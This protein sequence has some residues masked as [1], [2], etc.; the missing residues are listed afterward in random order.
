MKKEKTIPDFVA[1][2]KEML[3][4][5]QNEKIFDRLREKNKHSG[6]YYATLDGPVTANYTMGLHHAFNRTFKDAMIKFEAMEG[7]DQHYQNGFDAHG[8]PVE[9]WVEKELGINS[10]K[11]IET[12]GIERFVDKCMQRV[13]KYSALITESSIRLGQW[14]DWDHSYYTNS[15]E[16]I[17]AIWHFLKECDSHGWIS[18]SYRVSPWCTRC[19]TLVAEHDM[20]GYDVYRDVTC[21]AVFFRCPIRNSNDDILVWTTTPWTLC[22]NVA[23]AVNPEKDYSVVKVKS[24][25]RNIIVMSNLVKVLKSDAVKVLRQVKGSDLVGLE[26]ETC[27]PEL[28]KQNFTHHIV[29][30][31]EVD[32]KEGSGA[33]HIAPGCGESDF[34][35]GQRLGL[36]NIVP[37]D[38]AGN[39]Y[40]DFGILAGKNGNTD[41]TRDFVFEQLKQRGKLYYFHDYTHRYPHCDR[42]KQPL[43]YRLIPQWVIKMDELRPLLISAIDEVEFNPPFMKKRMLDWL[44]NMGDWSISRARYYG[45]PLPIYPCDHCGE[46]TVVGSLTELKNLSGE[47][48]K[49]DAMPHIH[50][51]YIDDIQ[52]KCPKCGQ[53]VARIKEVGDCWLDAGITPFSTKKYFSDPEFFNKNFPIEAVI[54]GKEQIRLWF[55]SLLVMSVVLTGK[56][57]YK[58]V[59][60]TPMLL[61]QNGKKLSKSAPNIV[62][63]DQCFEEIGADVIRYNFVAT[64][65]GNDVIFSRNTCDEVKRKLLGFWNSY[66]FLNTY[67]VIDQPDL[68]GYTPR[69]TDLTVLDKWL[70]TR[71]NQFALVAER[72]YKKQEFGTVAGEF[73]QVVEDLSNWY[74]RTNRRRFYKSE[75]DS[76]TKN[77]YFCLNYAIKNL[78]MVMFPIVPFMTEYIWQN[79]VRQL[80]KNASD[81]V[82]LFGYQTETFTVKGEHLVEDTRVAQN[83]IALASK[84]RN[85][86]QLK[87]KQ[88]LKEMF[89]SGTGLDLGEVLREYSDIIKDE[90]NIKNLNIVTDDSMFNEEFLSL[91]FRKAGAVL[92]G[93]VQRVKQT[94]ADMSEA[95]MHSC[96]EGFKE[97]KVD[98]AEFKGLSA[99]L[100]NLEKKPKSE[101]VITHENGLTVVL[102]I[103]LDEALEQEGKYREFVRALQVMRKD[104][105]FNVEDRIFADFETSD[106][107]LKAM[108]QRFLE[109]IK[110]EVLIKDI[111]P[112]KTFAAERTI[113]LGG[114]TITARLSK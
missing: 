109:K 28:N 7:Y 97:G 51:P 62:P 36:P 94:L 1:M 57:P 66:V 46:V 37:I 3:S 30:W 98:V 110:Q 107:E 86:N 96:V 79:A 26:Y 23:V 6:K 34:A 8:L 41:E 77:A 19:G 74:I 112:L 13:K 9:T 27:F 72:A 35:L 84:L 52:I 48:E 44:N 10:K 42:C 2:E 25:D 58:R 60:T 113:D 31:E 61:D 49:I 93:E 87:V 95:E 89:V 53:K 106:P 59:N 21:K 111:R 11:E 39:F 16:N 38:E 45:L 15:D 40:P 88:P 70:I 99:E 73:E 90:V 56:A 102:D 5:W 50:R 100:F 29:A 101:F 55:Y 64:P 14:M 65:L 12:Y 43:V 17:T 20:A 105:N 4:F 63:L 78:C 76:D 81:S 67:A 114:A 103:T 75:S 85:E 33:V 18:R 82:A 83:I 80:D 92:K 104:S 68:S 108:L 69:E 71:I 32:E 22:A 47:S 54:E 91:N 24:S